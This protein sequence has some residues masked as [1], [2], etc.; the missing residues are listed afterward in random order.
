MRVRRLFFVMSL[1]AA[2]GC[3]PDDAGAP[4]GESTG[5][6]SAEDTE[7]AAVE[8]PADGAGPRVVFVGTSLTAGLGLSTP[9]EAF[10]ARLQELA[11]SAGVPARMVNAGVSGETS[12]GGLRRIGWVLGDTVHVLVLELGANDGLRGLDPEALQDNLEAIIDS[13]RAHWPDARVVV[14]GM[15]APPNL[16]P[17]YTRAFHDVFPAVARSRSTELVPFLLEGVGGVRELNQGDGIHPTA[18]GHRMMA[19]TI[20]PVLEPVLRELE[21]GAAAR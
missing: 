4:A 3:G 15:E 8:V 10:S 5:A 17:R 13:T 21:V 1:M 12:A 7:R 19:R 14:V 6:S 9:D 11:D 20:W 2:S 16:G 18:E